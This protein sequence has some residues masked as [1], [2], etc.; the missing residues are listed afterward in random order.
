MN[1]LK[2]EPW[3][4]LINVSDQITYQAAYLSSEVN[5]QTCRSFLPEKVLE[6]MNE[7]DR[8]VQLARDHA[9]LMRGS[10]ELNDKNS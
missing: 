8:L 9:H 6:M 4:D 2:A 5:E 3:R 1:Q 7:M 10:Q